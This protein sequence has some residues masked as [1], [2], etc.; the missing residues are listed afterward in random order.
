MSETATSDHY[1]YGERR[2]TRRLMRYWQDQ[3]FMRPMPEENEIDPDT[4]GGDW[5]YCFLVQARD[6]ANTQDYNFTYLGEK[7]AQAYNDTEADE[8]S[9]FL[10][11][12]NAK[13]LASH[14]EKVIKSHAP[15]LD[16]GEFRTIKGHRVL[17]RQCLLPL[18]NDEGEVQAI[19]GG[20]NYKMVAG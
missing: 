20:M 6:V 17:F 5:D 12:P 18:G 7:I 4:L 9:E 19:F 2:L 15:V 3:R 13:A 10:A 8:F 16:E 1:P 14:L 11:G